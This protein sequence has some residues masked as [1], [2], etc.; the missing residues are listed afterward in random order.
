M[1]TRVLIVE[2]EL[3]LAEV[4]RE[5]LAEHDMDVSIART[6]EEAFRLLRDVSPQLIILDIMLPGQDGLSFLRVLRS[7][8]ALKNNPVL[9]VSVL[10]QQEHRDDAIAAGADDFLPKPFTKD[11]LL[12]AVRS[13]L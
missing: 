10:T 11:E 1:S 2:D 13:L 7:I 5:V 6:A 12:S 3:S 8:P 9:V 4:M